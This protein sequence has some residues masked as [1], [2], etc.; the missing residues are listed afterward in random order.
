MKRLAELAPKYMVVGRI[1]YAMLEAHVLFAGRDRRRV[2]REVN[3][4]IRR[5]KAA[6][7]AA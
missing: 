6:A 2:K 7:R 4:A 5:A 1:N 3:K